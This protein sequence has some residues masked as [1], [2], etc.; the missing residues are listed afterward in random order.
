M[1]QRRSC[2]VLLTIL[3]LACTANAQEP[4]FRLPDGT[5]DLQGIWTNV[6]VTPLERP[7]DLG[8]TAFFASV[9]EARAYAAAVVAQRDPD[10]RDGPATADVSRAYN[11]FWWDRGTDVVETLRTSLIVDPPDGRIPAQTDAAR[12]RAAERRGGRGRYDGPEDRPLAERC[13]IWPNEGPPML[14]SAYNNNYQIVQSPGYV[15]ILMEMIHDARIIPTDGRAHQADGVRHWLGDSV[16]HWEGDTLV[17][18]TI[19]FNDQMNFRGANVNLRVVERFTR[20]DEDTLTY[21]F[22]VEDETTW[23][24]SWSGEIPMLATQGPLYEYACHEGNESLI[25]VLSGARV[26][27]AAN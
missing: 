27:E 13:I 2:A 16:G 25:G 6:T 19:N 3:F 10:R 5:P 15:V 24:R 12:A 11:A 22:T 9:D 21:E 26:R 23:E 4:Q 18:E 14:P 8:D 7:V 1:N 20:S 17:V